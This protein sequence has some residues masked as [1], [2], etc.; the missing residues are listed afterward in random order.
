MNPGIVP[1]SR[2]D[3]VDTLATFYR[4]GGPL[5]VKLG[6]AGVV[7]ILSAVSTV[8][9]HTAAIAIAIFFLCDLG[10][11]VLKALDQY[12]LAGFE[13]RRA[14]RGFIKF[15]AA[16]VGLILT[17]TG[18]AVL[19]SMGAPSNRYVLATAFM[20]GAAYSFFWSAVKNLR[21]FYPEAVARLIALL[22]REDY[23]RAREP[24]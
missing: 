11:G 6:G 3:L 8:V 10:L 14:V 24:R 22:K 23:Q 15:G 13:G 16:V 21:H 1:V 7:A 2:Q 12:G 19:H 17:A 5:A 18:D 20:A 4:D 9:T